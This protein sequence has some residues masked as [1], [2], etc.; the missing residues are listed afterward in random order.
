MAETLREDLEEAFN[1]VENTPS[2]SQPTQEVTPTPAATPAELFTAPTAE[3]TPAEGT[4][5]SSTTE[6][7]PAEGTPTATK[8][9]DKPAES[10][11]TPVAAEE[12]KA[13]GSWSPEAREKWKD[14]PQD[15]QRE[16][17]RRESE[18]SRAFTASTEARKFANEFQKTVQPYMG[19]I[20]AE[21]STPLQAVNYMMQTAALFRVGTGA[22]KVKAVADIIHNYGVDLEMLDKHLAG[23]QQATD[24]PQEIVRRA[25]QQELAPIQQQHQRAQQEYHAQLDQELTTELNTFKNGREFYE[26]VRGVMADLIDMASQRG[27]S[28]SLT[29]AYERAILIH[30]P[31]RRVIEGRKASETAKKAQLEANRARAAAGGV[32]NSSGGSAA[33]RTPSS[34]QKTSLRDDILAAWDSK[35]GS[36]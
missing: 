16:I 8:A 9:E 22:Q 27:Q 32:V 12:L 13:P 3:E 15:V 35:T 20:A 10:T 1:K 24:S 2:D 25:V 30:E 34:N 23:H 17:K 33:S 28:L 11:P 19:F 31:V 6:E 7:T 26:D 14:V 36:I 5:T 4:P 21:G 18:I 29:D